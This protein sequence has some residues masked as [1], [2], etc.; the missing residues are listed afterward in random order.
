M[1]SV[2]LTAVE[3]LLQVAAMLANGYGVTP[4]EITRRTEISRRTLQRYRAFLSDRLGL[5]IETLGKD[6]REL[7]YRV[8]NAA[9]VVPVVRSLRRFVSPAR[10]RCARS[11]DGLRIRPG[12]IR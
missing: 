6:G 7:R 9:A 11:K 10:R 8:R 3:K 12:G 1:R 5:D 2:S 4:K